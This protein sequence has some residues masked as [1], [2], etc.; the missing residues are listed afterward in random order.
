VFYVEHGWGPPGTAK[1]RFF[2]GPGIGNYDMALL[3]NVRVNES[4]SLQLGV[5]GFNILSTRNFLDRNR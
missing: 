5:E 2:Y 1:R 4:K 3:N